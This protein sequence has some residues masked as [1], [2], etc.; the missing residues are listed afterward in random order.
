MFI[1]VYYKFVPSEFPTL[2]KQVMQSSIEAEYVSS[3]LVTISPKLF[4]RPEVDKES[5]ETWMEVYNLDALTEHSVLQ[6]IE[7]LKQLALEMGLPQPRAI[8]KFQS[9][10]LNQLMT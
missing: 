10:K 3:H 8:E 4:K 6:F 1:Y 2:L 7:R 9:I 5:R